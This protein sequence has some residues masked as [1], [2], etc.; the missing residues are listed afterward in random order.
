MLKPPRV[1]GVR[2]L[3][4]RVWSVGFE[5]VVVGLVRVSTL[6]YLGGFMEFGLEI[7]GSGLRGLSSGLRAWLVRV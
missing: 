7:Q 2:D 5:A 4:L 3:R 1:S 6:D